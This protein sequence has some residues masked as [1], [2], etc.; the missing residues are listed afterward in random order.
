MTQTPKA[1]RL[2]ARTSPIAH[3]HTPTDLGE[4]KTPPSDLALQWEEGRKKIAQEDGGGYWYRHLDGDTYLVNQASPWTR[5]TVQR[6]LKL[7]DDVDAVDLQCWSLVRA[8]DALDGIDVRA[9]SA[10]WGD[11]G[12]PAVWF[13]G[14]SNSEGMRILARCLARNYHHDTT[15]CKLAWQ[16]LLDHSDVHPVAFLLQI[17]PK[18]R[19]LPSEGVEYPHVQEV[20]GPDVQEAYILPPDSVEISKEFGTFGVDPFWPAEVLAQ[21]IDSYRQKSRKSAAS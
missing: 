1:V 9:V 14:G 12:T 10:N 3:E 5:G 4:V 15:T 11:R 21:R 7:G 8:L 16:I 17:D 18:F 20:G 2:A 6:V 19:A 13:L